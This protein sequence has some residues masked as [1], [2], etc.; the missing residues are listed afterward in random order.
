M[1]V[2]MWGLAAHPPAPPSVVT[3]IR[4]PMVAQGPQQPTLPFVLAISK[5]AFAETYLP[6]IVH[7]PLSYLK[8]QCDTDFFN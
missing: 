3:A 4:R 8:A 7:K 6:F 2:T 1:K 5:P